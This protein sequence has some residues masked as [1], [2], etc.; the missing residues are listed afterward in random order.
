MQVREIDEGDGE[1]KQVL[2]LQLQDCEQILR[3]GPGGDIRSYLQR[4]K[5][6]LMLSIF[7]GD[8]VPLKAGATIKCLHDTTDCEQDCPEIHAPGTEQ[9]CRLPA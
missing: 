5:R 7:L 3:T 4:K 1:R 8:K 2:T 6:A 9:C